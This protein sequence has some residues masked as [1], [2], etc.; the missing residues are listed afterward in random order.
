MFHNNIFLYLKVIPSASLELV[1]DFL[2]GIAS[3]LGAADRRARDAS[4]S[5]VLVLDLLG[6]PDVEDAGDER[7]EPFPA[8]ATTN[9]HVTID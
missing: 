8:T 6:F 7:P 3:G 2:G 5:G 9:L 1:R 4:T